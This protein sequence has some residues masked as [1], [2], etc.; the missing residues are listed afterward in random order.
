MTFSDVRQIAVEMKD[1]EECTSYGTPAFKTN[2]ALF[3]RYRPELDSIVVAIGFD[4]RESAIEEDPETYYIT[5]HYLNYT[6]V[7]VRLERI[8]KSALRDL[9]R[10]AKLFADSNKSRKKTAKK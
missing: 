10:H 6:W 4:D 8:K 2:G 3:V 1:I 9:L 7:L 5:D